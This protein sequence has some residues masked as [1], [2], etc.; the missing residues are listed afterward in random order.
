MPQTIEQPITSPATDKQ[1]VVG[2]DKKTY[3]FSKNISK[4][5]IDKYFAKKGIKAPVEKKE[6]TVKD[7]ALTEGIGKGIPSGAASSVVGGIGQDALEIGAT[8]LPSVGGAVGGILGKTPGAALGGLIGEDVRQMI[9]R[10]INMG[11]GIPDMDARQSLIEMGKAA[12]GQALLEKGGQ[13]AGEIFFKALD[14][15]VPHAAKVKG[16]P[17]LPSD[18]NPNGK[19]MRYV[20]DLLSNLAPSAKTMTA[21]REAQ[22]NAITT[23]AG[24]LA[25]GFSKFNGT[26][27]E[28]GILLQ[29]TMNKFDDALTSQMEA[30]R[31]TLPAGKRTIAQAMKDPVYKGIYD[32]QQAYFRT[33]LAKKIMGTNKPELI[34]GLIRTPKAGLEDTRRLM[35]LMNEKSPEIVGKVQNRVMRDIFSET[36]TGSKDPTLKGTSLKG[37]SGSKLKDTL[38]GIG[39]E[40]LK[41]LYGQK[42]YKAITDFE[43]I[44]KHIDKTQG[45]GV[46][47]FLNLMFI[48]PFRAG[49]S[50][51]A[52]SKVTGMGLIANRAARIITSPEGV[53]LYENYIRAT[54][55]Q[56]PRLANLAREELVQYNKRSDAEYIQEEKDAE[57]EFKKQQEGK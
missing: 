18:L 12:A 55:A 36:M 22:K 56:T 11:R 16:I 50:V 32:E 46:G 4:E 49:T 44:V 6:A 9:M 26:S 27:E 21:F 33:E 52:I 13:K 47:R 8:A 19:V 3:I 57:A 14:K 40:K 7:T 17:L 25:N 35:E 37:F 15:F 31:K 39:E 1:Q 42:G 28:L 48:L 24:K 29:N 2:P 41:V 30:I 53:K 54:A 45:S 34:A 5:R 23:Q 51:S 38:D 10:P 20:E 43:N